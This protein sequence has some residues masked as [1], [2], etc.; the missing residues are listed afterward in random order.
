MERMEL[1]DEVNSLRDRLEERSFENAFWEPV[2]RAAEAYV[3]NL[4]SELQHERRAERLEVASRVLAGIYGFKSGM[5]DRESQMQ[6]RMYAAREALELADALIALVD[7]K[8]S[9]DR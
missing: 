4:A 3:E 6:Q 1:Q 9:D 2:S 8:G 7:S 5:A